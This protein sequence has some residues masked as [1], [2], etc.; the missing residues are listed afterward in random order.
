MGELNSEK[1]S[2]VHYQAVA[3]EANRKQ[4][5]AEQ[6]VGEVYR[7]LRR[8]EQDVASGR[9]GDGELVRKLERREKGLAQ[10][11][12]DVRK[13]LGLTEQQLFESQ[14][15]ERELQERLYAMGKEYREKDAE[16]VHIQQTALGYKEYEVEHLR[17]K[18]K[19]YEGIL[20]DFQV[21]DLNKEQQAALRQYENVVSQPI[22]NKP[23]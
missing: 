23:G 19:E 11:L 15:R 9:V 10:L 3:R 7:K 12:A 8:V 2:A 6:E 16:R 13:K 1:Q 17:K 20:S 4:D 5:M 14:G 18:V 21:M 22:L